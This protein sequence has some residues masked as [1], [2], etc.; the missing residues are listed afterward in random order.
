MTVSHADSNETQHLK[1]WDSTLHKLLEKVEA[2]SIK[3]VC[4]FIN[5]INMRD[6]D[7]FLTPRVEAS[8]EYQKT[9]IVAEGHIFL[10]TEASSNF[11][12]Q[13]FK[14]LLPYE[15]HLKTCEYLF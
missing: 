14:N 3:K 9:P 5:S 8:E 2:K 15:S 13:K 12:R 4:T 1:R 7:I 11:V 6:S 10:D